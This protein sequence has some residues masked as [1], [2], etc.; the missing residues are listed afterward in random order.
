VV[1]TAPGRYRAR[2]V[3][4]AA[5]RWTLT[6]RVGSATVGLGA[7]VVRRPTSAP[8]AELDEPFAVAVDGD[9]RVVVADRAADR[10]VRI[11]PAT[12]AAA[13]VAELHE[14]LDVAAGPA[15]ELYVISDERVVRVDG[16]A[17]AT[18]ASGLDGATGV[19]V[20]AAGNVYVAEYEN[21]IRR[22][23]ARTGAV[24][25]VA[26]NGQPGDGG[27]GG[28]ASRALVHHP[29]GVAVAADG[30]I[31]VADSASNRVRRIAADGTIAT[32]ASLPAPIHVASGP[33]GELFVVASNQVHR[34]EPGGASAIVAGTGIEA[35]S[36][37]GVPAADAHLNVPNHVAVAADGTLYF[38][39]FGARR[40]RR[41]DGRTGLITT[42]AR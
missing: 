29:H 15:G 3:F 9:G 25:T 28:P 39:E 40:V 1:R 24:T 26:G 6:G 5:G 34:I 2:L 32:I 14:P 16:A 37:D 17:A 11:D 31:V 20:D 35:T 27:D 38:S 19:A 30:A 22:V 10:V 41:V 23:D 18:V 13:T 4:P 21:R 33:G 7:V 36:R 8:V 12:A 42:I